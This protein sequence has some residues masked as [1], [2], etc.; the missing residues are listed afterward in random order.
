MLLETRKLLTA[1]EIKRLTPPKKDAKGLIVRPGAMLI[2]V[3]GIST[4]FGEQTPYFFDPEWK[5]RY[6]ISP[7]GKSDVLYRPEGYSPRKGS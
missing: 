6:K 5:V 1:D 4:I 2:L 7:P 3:A